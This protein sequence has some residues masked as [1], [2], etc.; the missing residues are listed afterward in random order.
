MLHNHPPEIDTHK[1]C[2]QFWRLLYSWVALDSNP[3][4]GVIFWY[5][6]F[7]YWKVFIPFFIGEIAV[8]SSCIK[9]VFVQKSG[10]FLF[11]MS[12]NRYQNIWFWW[13]GL[14]PTIYKTK[15]AWSN[16]YDR[17][18]P[19]LLRAQKGR[20]LHAFFLTSNFHKKNAFLND[21]SDI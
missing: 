9:Y 7:Q 12:C 3:K 15:W 1:P 11:S 14:F 20:S 17:G 6:E 21:Y 2:L 19:S 13:R 8:F 18:S 4:F 16:T 10:L 5:G